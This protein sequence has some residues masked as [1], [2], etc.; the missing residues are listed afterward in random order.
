MSAA[1]ATQIAPV[2]GAPVRRT[3]PRGMRVVAMGG[4]MDGGSLFG[5]SKKAKVEEEDS[6]ATEEKADE[7][8]KS[9]SSGDDVDLDEL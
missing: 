3:K 1:F 5:M 2:V 8:A 7:K 9:D 4:R 6:E